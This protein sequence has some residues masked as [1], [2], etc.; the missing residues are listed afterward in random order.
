MKLKPIP[1]LIIL[2][3][4]TYLIG[5]YA[6]KVQQIDSL[7]R[8]LTKPSQADTF[9]IH[10]LL[11]ISMK[12]QSFETDSA[13][14][15]ARA[16]LKKAE[17]IN[18][19]KGRADAL[20]HIG[21]LNRDQD[22][23]GEALKKMFI[24]LTLYRQIN[25]NVQIANALNDISIIYAT[26][27]DYKK[28]LE[29]F[30]QALDIFQKTGD[31]KGESY[32]L[33]N[34]GLIYQELKDEAMAKKYFLRSLK[35]KEKNH[36]LY[37]ISRGY[38]NLGSI[39]E[40]N[41]QWKEALAYYFK[42][43]KIFEEIKDLQAQATNYVAIA[44]IIS[45]Q[46]K[47]NEAKQYALLAIAKA[48]EV[49]SLSTM[50]EVC[51]FL[52]TLEEK[53]NNYKSALA[54][55]KQYNTLADSIANENHRANLVEL[56]TKFN[57]EEKEREIVLLKKDKELQQAILERKNVVTSALGTGV[58]LMVVIIGLLYYAYRATKSKRDALAVKNI[59]I[60][61]QKDDLDKLNKEKDRFFSILSHDLKGPLSS[62]KGLSYLLTM[63]KDALTPDELLHI[64]TKINGSL[65][66]LTDLINNILEWSMTTSQKREW[67]FSKIDTTNLIKKNISMYRDIAEGKGVNLVY[68]Q[69]EEFHGYADYHAI[70][71]VIRNLLSNS[72]KYSHSNKEVVIGV[73]KAAQ[74]LFISVKDYGVGM[75]LEIQDNLF[76][77]K[78][79]SSQ[80]G[81]R[82]EK[83]T[84]LGLT[85]CME[86]MKEN[87]GD[88]QVRS[89]VGEG[90]EFII[91]IPACMA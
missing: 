70:D 82:N 33:N 45:E 22:K 26:T 11:T 6:Q 18:Y 90:S 86:L 66:Y 60:G 19:T 73:S 64:R 54:Y 63:S 7:K 44:R 58:I 85:L 35:I 17:A 39:S 15:Y 36:D 75:P 68:D 4:H 78:R 52:A 16:S 2:F 42:A 28:S 40:N 91:S 74:T 59:E 49:K 69:E 55:Q 14:L 34:I 50:L 23:H 80:P 21:R 46:G 61:Q 12:Y 30:E 38:N 5:V 13:L 67:S 31:E 65:D 53:Q 51:K 87:R 57:F 43:D 48:E 83:G 72:I 24:A 9:L 37:G 47:Y 71:T 10:T 88:I 81:T 62:L 77:L 1:V 76:K 32:A 3:L 20:L 27:G 25:D 84:G 56:K 29:Y 89:K 8:E 79:N 41:R